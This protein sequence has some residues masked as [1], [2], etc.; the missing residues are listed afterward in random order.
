MLGSGFARLSHPTRMG[1]LQ[2]LIQ[3]TLSLATPS[4]ESTYS[5]KG[6]SSPLSPAPIFPTSGCGFR[7]KRREKFRFCGIYLPSLFL[8]TKTGDTA[9][10]GIF[11][12]CDWALFSIWAKPGNE[13]RL[14]VWLRQTTQRLCTRYSSRKSS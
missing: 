9:H 2:Q 7:S 1:R 6:R 14:T 4:K 10:T 13:G 11:C 12:K 5:L 3:A 8:Q